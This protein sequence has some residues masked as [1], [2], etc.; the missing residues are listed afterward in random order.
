MDDSMVKVLELLRA[1]LAELRVMHPPRITMES[2]L[3]GADEFGPEYETVYV[4]HPP[5]P[6]PPN[7]PELVE[8]S[9]QRPLE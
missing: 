8:D 6:S 3:V 2:V 9:P 1:I 4:V 5:S 7:I